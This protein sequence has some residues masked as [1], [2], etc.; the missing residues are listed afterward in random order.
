MVNVA[1]NDP[2]LVDIT[3]TG[4]V[5]MLL[6][7]NLIVIV[8]VAPKFEPVTVTVVPVIPLVGDRVISVCE[9]T[10]NIVSTELTPSLAVI[11]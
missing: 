8:L 2:A 1:A 5:D 11:L 7:S 10:V 4:L 6:L 3:V 9:L